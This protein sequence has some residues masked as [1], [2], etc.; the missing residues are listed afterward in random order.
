MAHRLSDQR[1]VSEPEMKRKENPEA[2]CR[3][4]DR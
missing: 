3:E 1:K 2:D 4:E